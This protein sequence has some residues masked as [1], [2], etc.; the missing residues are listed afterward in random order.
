MAPKA[1]GSQT[2]GVGKTLKHFTSTTDL[3]LKKEV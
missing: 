3:D 1:K 2:V